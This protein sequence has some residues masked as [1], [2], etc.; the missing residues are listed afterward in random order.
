MYSDN[1]FYLEPLHNWDNSTTPEIGL[2]FLSTPHSLILPRKFGKRL[3]KWPCSSREQLSL[4]LM[5]LLEI[6]SPG[7]E[8]TS[9]WPKI[10][11]KHAK[12]LLLV[13]L[14]F[15]MYYRYLLFHCFCFINCFVLSYLLCF[16][17]EF[18]KLN[19]PVFIILCPGK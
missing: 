3:T 16:E 19:G 4:W 7:T 8:N 2:R 12:A 17:W 11:R 10:C 18:A 1:V 15:V 9:L 13:T 14:S 6:G 5:L